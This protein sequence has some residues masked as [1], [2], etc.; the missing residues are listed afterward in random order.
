M[1]ERMRVGRGARGGTRYNCLGWQIRQQ[2]KKYNIK[3]IVAFWRPL[4]DYFTHNNQPKTDA[5]NGGEYGEDVRL[6]GRSGEVQ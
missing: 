4:V 3:Y 5:R 1:L 6:G 2:R